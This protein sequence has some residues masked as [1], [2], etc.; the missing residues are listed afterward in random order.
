M[1]RVLNFELEFNLSESKNCYFLLKVSYN[2]FVDVQSSESKQWLK[3]IIKL[4]S[5]SAHI[6]VSKS[7]SRCC[8]HIIALLFCVCN[9][10]TFH[11]AGLGW[12]RLAWML[13]RTFLVYTVRRF[14]WW[15]WTAWHG[16]W[17]PTSNQILHFS[18]LVRE[19]SYLRLFDL[20]QDY[21]MN[22]CVSPILFWSR[23]RSNQCMYW[24]CHF[25]H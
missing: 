3:I 7:W 25:L 9:L 18:C 8:L 15:G 22:V 19:C 4:Q 16:Q 13:C 2:I 12:P 20:H 24:P 1:V 6:W 17:F 5:S 21:W 14:L 11:C 23:Y 10:R